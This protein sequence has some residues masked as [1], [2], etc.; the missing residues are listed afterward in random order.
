MPR[1]RSTSNEAVAISVEL[2]SSQ[3]TIALVECGGRVR[4]RRSAKILWNRPPSATLELCLRA[5]DDTLASA[6]DERLC[7]RGL[8]LILPGSLDLT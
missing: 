3:A 4:Q 8:G 5:I 1:P 7:V 2:G 6:R